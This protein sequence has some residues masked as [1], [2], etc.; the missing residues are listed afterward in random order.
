M[1]K[2]LQFSLDKSK[3]LSICVILCY[4][5]LML[6]VFLYSHQPFSL[7][8]KTHLFTRLNWHYLLSFSTS[9][10]RS[11]IDSFIFCISSPNVWYSSLMLLMLLMMFCLH[12]LRRGFMHEWANALDWAEK[13]PEIMHL[14]YRLRCSVLY[15]SNRLWLYSIPP[16]TELLGSSLRLLTGQLLI[17]NINHSADKESEESRLVLHVCKSRSNLSV[18]KIN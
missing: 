7:C 14:I 18:T 2:R 10:S 6:V 16:V 17:H 4:F 1:C 5:S 3:T 9:V 12:V 15:Q 13:L 11:S 8:I